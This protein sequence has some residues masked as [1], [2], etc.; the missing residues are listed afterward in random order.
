MTFMKKIKYYNDNNS[1]L[2]NHI[3]YTFLINDHKKIFTKE[4]QILFKNF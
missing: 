1:N 2:T 4:E 3:L